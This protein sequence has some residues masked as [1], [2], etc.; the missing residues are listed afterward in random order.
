M[1]HATSVVLFVM[2]GS[3]PCSAWGTDVRFGPVR[4]VRTGFAFAE[5]PVSAPD[6][7]LFFTDI[8]DGDGKI[9]RL[10]ESGE[11][12]V[13]CRNSNKANGL[14]LSCDGELIACEMNGRISAYSLDGRARRTLAACFE[15]R[16]FNAPNDLAVDDHGGFYFTDPFFGAPRIRPPQRRSAV[17]YRSA[18]GRITRLIDDLA[19]P[20]GVVLSPGGRTLYV[21]PTGQ[22]VMMAYPVLG[23]GRLGPGRVFCRLR[24]SRN[25]LWPGGDGATVD[26][27]GNV[28]ITSQRGVQVFDASG[29]FLALIR[30]PESPSN[31]AFGGQEGRTLYITAR[32][33]LYSV[34]VMCL[35]PAPPMCRCPE[36]PRKR[37]SLG[38]RVW[39]RIQGLG[40]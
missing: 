22:R 3:V 29:R 33:S 5:G 40:P 12:G 30:V 31:V 9:Y 26:R 10:S 18:S 38:V 20:N 8:H 15:G 24:R 17:Y 34:E 39:S 13:F 35:C 28:Y 27:V 16:R 23:P 37:C 25:P 2:V 1:R 7:S 32:T 36:V 4:C 14:G 19:N 6:G 21:I 11:L